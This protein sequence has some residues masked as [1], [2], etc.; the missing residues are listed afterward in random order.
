LKVP[1]QAFTAQIITWMLLTC[2]TLG[3]TKMLSHS[4]RQQVRA[5]VESNQ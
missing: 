1:S 4:I 2:H 5:E 3:Q